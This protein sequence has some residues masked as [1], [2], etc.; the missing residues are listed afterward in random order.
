MRYLAVP[1]VILGM[2]ALAVVLVWIIG[3]YG[4]QDRTQRRRTRWIVGG[5][6]VALV[7]GV[8]LLVV[9]Y[10]FPAY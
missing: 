9:H 1:L 7:A 10:G 4:S 2:A 8:A 6:T 5:I 3:V